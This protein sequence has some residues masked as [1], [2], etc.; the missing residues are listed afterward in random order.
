MQLES[1]RIQNFRSINDSGN[2]EMSRITALVGRN[3]SGKSNLLLGLR[4]LNPAEGFQAL[5]PVKDFPRH[6]KLSEC[7]GDTM[8]VSSLWRLTTAEQYELGQIFP[9]AATATH[10]QITRPYEATRSVSFQ[11]LS[12]LDFDKTS[13]QNKIANIMTAVKAASEILEEP[14][15]TAL[16]AAAVAFGDAI[17]LK[18]TKREWAV[19]ASP[20]IAA[21]RAAIADAN[22]RLTELQEKEIIALEQLCPTITGDDA[23][24]N[25]AKQW[26]I[27][28]IPVF[29]YLAEYSQLTGHQNTAEY[30]QRKAQS[31]P[32]EADRNFEKLCKVAGLDP[33]NLDQLR[34]EQK[35]E[36]RNQIANRASAV[37]T[38]VIR[39]LWHDRPLKVR[40]NLDDAHFD[41]LISDPTTTFDVEVN[42]DER[43]RGFRWFFSFYITFSADTENGAAKNAILLF[44]EPG[45][46][47]HIQ[48]QRDLLTHWENDFENQIVYTTHSPFMI[49]MQAL[50]CLRTVNITEDEGTTVSNDPTGDARTLAPIR[51]ALDYPLCR[52]A[53]YW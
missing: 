49:P 43:S 11:N 28:K 25:N 37:V 31:Q 41:T 42:L 53:F 23:S 19:R 14:H 2:V 30:L 40:F 32:T 20:A 15:K 21:L 9:R 10:V 38:G 22:T 29:I 4:S 33:A 24:H 18:E 34:G 7:S 12:P 1:F 3:E 50:D 26:A 8:V 52:Y 13:V 17:T 39:K 6:R 47:L 46:H 45:L 36:E 5:N 51:A 27:A 48:S 16:E 44:D 35:Y